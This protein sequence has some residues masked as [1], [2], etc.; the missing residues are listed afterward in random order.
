M[1]SKWEVQHRIPDEDFRKQMF[2]KQFELLAVLDPAW[3]ERS[4]NPRLAAAAT[5]AR[6]VRATPLVS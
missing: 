6:L 1:A 5:S 3:T 2:T 4:G